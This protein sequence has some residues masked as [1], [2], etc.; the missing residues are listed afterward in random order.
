[1]KETLFIAQH[2]PDESYSDGST[3]SMGIALSICTC[4]APYYTCFFCAS[5]SYLHN[6]CSF[7]IGSFSSC[8]SFSASSILLFSLYLCAIFLSCCCLFAFIAIV[9]FSTNGSPRNFQ[10]CSSP[11][12]STIFLLPLSCTSMLA[13]ATTIAGVGAL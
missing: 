8:N 13:S 10:L 2:L 7:Q 11:M 12:R 6:S 5:L 9:T 1:M 4:C 3:T